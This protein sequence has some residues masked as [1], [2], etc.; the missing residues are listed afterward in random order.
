MPLLKPSITN[1]SFHQHGKELAVVIEG[2]NFWFC[3]KVHVSSIPRI[4]IEPENIS[5]KTIQFNY[6]PKDESDIPEGDTIGVQ[7]FSHFSNPIRKPNIP[8]KRKVSL[9]F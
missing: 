6:M 4:K 5:C 7:L 8:V 9:N 2:N 3:T 1:V